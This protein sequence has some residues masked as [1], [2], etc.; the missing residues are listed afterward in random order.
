MLTVLIVSVLAAGFIFKYNG[1][2][3][4]ANGDWKAQLIQQNTDLEKVLKKQNENDALEKVLA[5]TPTGGVQLK[6]VI[7]KDIKTNNYRIEHNLPPTE[8]RT[9]W[10]SVTQTTGLIS[11]VS[12]LSIIISAGIVAGE[13]ITGTIKLLIIR[14]LNRWK[15]LLSKYVTVLLFAF[16]GLLILFSASFLVG[17]LFYG[18][19]GANQPYLSYI[20]G[21]VTEVNMVR[22]IFT[23][24]VYACVDLL[25]MVTFAFMVSTVFRNNALAVGTSIFLLFTGN[26]LVSL[27]SKYN[28][29]KYV[30][31]ANTDLTQYAKGEPIV[32]GMTLTFSFIVLIVYFMIFIA[33]SWIFFSRRAISE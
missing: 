15:V 16:G 3:T 25:M 5:Q 9:L 17:G 32:K 31:F 29:V 24:Y 14:P 1:Q 27:L 8:G 18:F 12:L 22:H 10:G 7:E 4:Y 6:D 11:L 30:L 19:S 23:T 13:F 21:N 28:W 20:N 33:I 2:T 26:V